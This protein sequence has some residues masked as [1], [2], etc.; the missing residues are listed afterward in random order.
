MEVKQVRDNFQEICRILYENDLFP[1]VSDYL[2]NIIS[3]KDEKVE[4]FFLLNQ[5]LLGKFM[6]VIQMIR[7]EY[8]KNL[9]VIIGYIEVFSSKSFNLLQKQ[10]RFPYRSTTQSQGIDWILPMP[11]NGL[12]D[13]M[14]PV[15]QCYMDNWDIP[16]QFDEDE[17][18]SLKT[19]RHNVL[20]A[21][22]LCEGTGLM[23]YHLTI[24]SY[25]RPFLHQC[26]Y[27]V[28]VRSGKIRFSHVAR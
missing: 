25:S 15:F 26:L 5:F 7:N 19:L 9:Q 1:V 2:I 28:L 21:A 4:A 23:A 24:S 22:L 10:N 8:K 12:F 14:M 18:T 11:K 17:C 20:E 13:L 6:Q 3:Q 16:L 27:K